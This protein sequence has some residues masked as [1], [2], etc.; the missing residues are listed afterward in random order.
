MLE[1]SSGSASMRT[2]H[3]Q[4]HKNNNQR[5]ARNRMGLRSGGYVYFFKQNWLRRLKMNLPICIYV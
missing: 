4:N 5:G 3:G 1:M 2:G